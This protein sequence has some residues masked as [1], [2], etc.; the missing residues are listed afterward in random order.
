MSLD[1]IIEEANWVVD[2][3]EAARDVDSIFLFYRRKAKLQRLVDLIRRGSAMYQHAKLDR[4]ATLL[5]ALHYVEEV[6]DRRRGS[7]NG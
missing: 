5:H 2:A 7:F 6:Y 4:P 1:S 3:L